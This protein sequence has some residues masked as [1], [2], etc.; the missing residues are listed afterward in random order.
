MSKRFQSN[1]QSKQNNSVL[2][3]DFTYHLFVISLR[4][5]PLIFVINRKHG[6]RTYTVNTCKSSRV[7]V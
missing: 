4:Y 1:E 6:D 3:F 2:G 7:N 5:P